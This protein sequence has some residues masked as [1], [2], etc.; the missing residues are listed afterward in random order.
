M[1]T[2]TLSWSSARKERVMRMDEFVFHSVE[3]LK[4]F[5]SSLP[6]HILVKITVSK[7]DA[8][9]PEE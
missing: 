7:E 6:D 3:E 8:D 1:N 9:E 5:L 2:S 4:K